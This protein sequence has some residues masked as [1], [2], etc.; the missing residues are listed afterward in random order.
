MKEQVFETLSNL[1]ERERTILTFL[2]TFLMV[3]IFGTVWFFMDSSIENKKAAIADKEVMIQ[4]MVSM[5]TLYQKAQRRN[6]AMKNSISSSNVNLNSDISTVRESTGVSISTLKE[7]KPRKKGD[8]SIERIEL[9]FRNVP[10][11]QVMAFLYG[12]ENRS[13]YVFIDSISIKKRFNLQNY[14]VSVV[15][16]T[17]KKEAGVE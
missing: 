17:L 11:E 10:L 12:I 15:I 13:R 5:K 7:L 8:V 9:S 1:S 14:D 3:F 16:A 4:K 2:V 6:E